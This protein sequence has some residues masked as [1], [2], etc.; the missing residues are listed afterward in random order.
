MCINAV[1]C[2]LTPVFLILSVN[3]PLLLLYMNCAPWKQT[4]FKYL[5][6]D[7]KC[8]V[9]SDAYAV[10]FFNSNTSA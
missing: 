1:S 8:S 6:G 9:A 5:N 2:V 7:M 4:V 3:P 10:N